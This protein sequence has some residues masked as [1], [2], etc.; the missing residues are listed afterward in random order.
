MNF[1]CCS[2]ATCSFSSRTPYRL[3]QLALKEPISDSSLRPTKRSSNPW[4]DLALYW[5]KLFRL[6][7]P[8]GGGDERTSEPSPLLEVWRSEPCDSSSG[9]ISSPSKDIMLSWPKSH[10]IFL[11]EMNVGL[12]AKLRRLSD[13][14]L[15]GAGL[16]FVFE[17][18]ER[19]LPFRRIDRTGLDP[20]L[21]PNGFFEFISGIS[22]RGISMSLHFWVSSIKSFNAIEEFI[23]S[24][25]FDR[26]KRSSIPVNDWSTSTSSSVCCTEGGK[27]PSCRNLGRVFF[28][29]NR[30]FIL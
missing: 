1:M 3:D 13:W 16:V 23:S 30:A 12:S 24:S 21:L 17:F 4:L 26:P 29:R 7:L 6:E 8:P 28:D 14:L 2:K 20:R 27:L 15:A 10:R 11:S 18:M 5:F 22:F 9:N 19:P 25:I